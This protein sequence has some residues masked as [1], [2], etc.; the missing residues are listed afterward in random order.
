ME[1][2]HGLPPWFCPSCADGRP[3][4]VFQTVGGSA[5]HARTDCER[6]TAGTQRAHRRGLVDHPVERIT[7]AEAVAYLYQPCP[8]C[9]QPKSTVPAGQPGERVGA[10]GA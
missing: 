10:T 1:C 6:L 9:T 8:A 2:T 3:T 5:Y 4:W 7:R